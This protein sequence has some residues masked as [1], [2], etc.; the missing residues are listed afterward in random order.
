MVY[1]V[2]DR[3]RA[4]SGGAAKHQRTDLPADNAGSPRPGMSIASNR[5]VPAT[6]QVIDPVLER[7]HRQDAQQ[8]AGWTTHGDVISGSA[9]VS[10][11]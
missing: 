1:E 7:Q 3:L 5:R 9:L 4:T 6:E 8:Q 2:Q 11:G 10:S